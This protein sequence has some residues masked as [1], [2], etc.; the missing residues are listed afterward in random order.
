MGIGTK[1]SAQRKKRWKENTILPI[2]IATCEKRKQESYPFLVSISF[3]PFFFFPMTKYPFISFSYPLSISSPSLS[4]LQICLSLFISPDPG[5]LQVASLRLSASFGVFPASFRLQ[6]R[7]PP[8]D[9]EN[10]ASWQWEAGVVAV[11]I[12]RRG[13]EN[14]AS[15]Q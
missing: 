3:I 2:Y 15:R 14:S 1:W 5:R 6:K 13:R 4:F 12:R 10:P 7:T 8:R 9:S 11:K